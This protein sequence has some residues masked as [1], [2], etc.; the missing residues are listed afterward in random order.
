MLRRRQVPEDDTRD[1]R[2]AHLLR[3]HH[4]AVA[5]DESTLRIDQN[6][7]SEAI[8]DDARDDLRDLG[9]RVR[10]GI[11]CVGI[12]ELT[13]RCSIAEGT[14]GAFCIRF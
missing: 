6:G 10:A 7:V 2:Q 12:S 14:I 13:D 1:R 5:S 3:R 4:P 9:R 11:F 8:F